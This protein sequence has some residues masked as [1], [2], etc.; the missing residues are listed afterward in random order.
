MEIW[1]INASH[2]SQQPRPLSDC[3]YSS[4]RH[5]MDTYLNVN[6]NLSRGLSG[7]LGCGGPERRAVQNVEG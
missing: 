3:G 2:M 5:L 4:W 6:L 1:K 7:P